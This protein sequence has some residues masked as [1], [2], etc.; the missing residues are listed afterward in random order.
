MRAFVAI[1]LEQ[2]LIATLQDQ[3]HKIQARIGR[4]L[5]RWVRPEGVHLTLKFLGE[6]DSGKS[7][8]VQDVL[9]QVSAEVSPFMI[10]VSGFGCFPSIRKPRVLWVGVDEESGRLGQL[11]LLLEHELERLGFAREKRA[12]HPHLTLG[13][14]KRHVRGIELKEVA[15]QLR[16]VEVEFLGDQRVD[17]VHLIRSDLGPG[18]ARYSTLAISNLEG[19]SE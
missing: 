19:G 18:G 11:Q 10:S 9:R 7:K 14:V 12:F 8:E 15:Q 13:R 6:I 1:E 2:D 3:S 5:V 17:K 16:L 4:D